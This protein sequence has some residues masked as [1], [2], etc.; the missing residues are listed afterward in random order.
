MNIDELLKTVKEYNPHANLTLIKKA[1]Q[2]AQEA[3][4]GQ[5]RDS[6]EPYIHHPLAVAEILTTLRADSATLCASLLHDVLEDTTITLEVIKPEFGEEIAQLVEGLTKLSKLHF[7]NKEAYNA[8]NLRKV[9]LATAKDVRV[10]LI[11][12]ADRLHNMK[13][14]MNLRPDKQ[15][16]IATETLEIYA[17]IAHKLGMWRM[18]GELE[19]LSLRYLK[20]EVYQALRHAISEKRAQREKVTQEIIALLE[21]KLTEKGILADVKGRAKY[22]YSIYQKMT[23]KNRDLSQIYDLHAVRIIAKSIQDC[24]AAL[25][26]VHDIWKP[27]PNRFKDYISLPKANGYQSLHT[28]V[29]TDK[30]KRVEIQI[31]TEAMHH[32]AEEGVAAHWRYQGT[33]RDKEFDKKIAWLKELLEWKAHSKDAR[34]FI[35]SL[36]VD[37]FAD[38]IVVFT[39]KGDPIP[40]PVGSTPVDFGYAVH[41]SI[42][43]H[44]AKAKINGKL[45]PLD[46]ELKSGDIVEIL[47]QKNAGPSRQWLKFVKTGKAR[48]KIL[49]AL[50]IVNEHDPKKGNERI[51]KEKERAERSQHQ[52]VVHGKLAPVKLSKCCLPKFGDPIVA[53][54]TKDKKI[55]VHTKGCSN[56]HTLDRSKEVLVTWKTSSK[57]SLTLLIVVK[58]RVAI[59]SDILSVFG[60][61]R[62]NITRVNTK[63]RKENAVLRISF[64]FIED[65]LLDALIHGIKQ[66]HDVVEVRVE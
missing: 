17:P 33:V 24:Y 44:C 20:P 50:N 10:M 48:S 31:R 1:Y 53:Y 3:H 12:L 60:E 16:R 15:K 2:F 34:E 21:K 8:E 26:V 5:H 27:V 57:R 64:P 22:F 49:A 4:K 39:P 56:V 41:S 47:I 25:G 66:I 59:L 35:E 36:K 23:K 14:L 62:I 38:E 63:S 32:L 9:I 28:T 29:L 18:K 55:T 42:G 19:D 13:T 11:K 58:D 37:L 6:G 65:D 40:L 7:D 54:Y 51:A 43:E 30:G 46:T 61:H 45:V 52:V